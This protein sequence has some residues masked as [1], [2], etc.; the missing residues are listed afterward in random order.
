MPS[1]LDKQLLL[2]LLLINAL[3]AAAFLAWQSYQ[4][5][6][7]VIQ[8][9]KLEARGIYH[10]VVLTR[11]LI[12][13]WEGVYIRSHGQFER[14]TPSGFTKSLADLGQAKEAPFSIKLAFAGNIDPDHAPDAFEQQVIALMQKKMIR[15]AWEVV[16]KENHREFKYAGPLIF[17]SDCA[18]C[19]AGSS[20]SGIIGCITVSLHDADQFFTTLS[21]KNMYTALYLAGTFGVIMLL[22]WALLNRFVLT[23]LRK[24]DAA[25]RRVEQGDLDVEVTLSDSREWQSVGRN[26]NNMVHALDRQQAVLKQ[27]V[28]K[29]VSGMQSAYDELKRME[30]YKADFFTNITHD[31]KTP[32]TAM[33]GALTLLERKYSD[34]CGPYLDILQRNCSKLA[35]MVQALLDCA[36]LESGSL[37]LDMRPADMAELVEDAIL[38]AMP[39]AWDREID[40][41]YQVPEQRCMAMIDIARMEQVMANLLS[42]AVKFSPSG[43]TVEV[44]IERESYSAG[45]KPEDFIL[46]EFWLVSV[47]DSGQGIPEESMDMVFN[48]FFQCSRNGD[49]D[50][51]GLGLSIVKGIVEIHGGQ[52]GVRTRRGRG[53]CFWFSVPVL[54]QEE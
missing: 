11:Q 16:E 33:K 22:L 17:D 52:A 47:S 44:K 5:K 26:F 53:T 40:I 28:K 15:E 43:S 32:I 51:L 39:L 8:Q 45:D 13:K 37:E 10:Y 1:S 4:E 46:H 42:N 24:L 48:K 18:S 30:Q 20:K 2:F 41:S 25:A 35:S 34:Q 54:E 27:E 49:P 19:H 23:P 9:M 38:M 12:S 21:R 29:A 7:A 36:R 14:K 3:F 50:G 6:E 31:L